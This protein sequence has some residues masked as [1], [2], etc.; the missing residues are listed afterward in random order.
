MVGCGNLL[1]GDDAAGPVLVRHAGRPGPARRACGWST[2]APPAWTSRSRCAACRGSS[3]WTRRGWAS[4]RAPSTGCP[5]PSSS[6]SPP[7]GEPAPFRWDQA[8][9]F[10]TWLLKDEYPEDITVWLVEGES[11][12][13]GA[14]LTPGCAGLCR[15]DRR[16]DR[17]RRDG[18]ESTVPRVSRSRHGSRRRSPASRRRWRPTCVVVEEHGRWIVYLDAVLASGAVRRKV[19][20]HHDERRAVH[21]ARIFERNVRRCITVPRARATPEPPPPRPTIDHRPSDDGPPA[22]A[23]GT[24]VSPRTSPRAPAARRPALARRHAPAARRSRRR[25]PPAL[26]CGTRRRRVARGPEFMRGCALDERHRA[27]G[28]RPRRRRPRH[29]LQPRRPRRRR[30]GVG[31]ARGGDHRRARARSSTR[32]GSASA[33]STTRPSADGTT[34][35]VAAVV[36]SARASA[37]IEQG[38]FG[39]AVDEL[40]AGAAAAAEAGSPLLAGSLRLTRAELLRERLDDPAAAA[41]EADLAR[42]AA[43]TDRATRTARRTAGDARAWPVR[44]LAGDRARRS[45]RGGGRPDRGRRRSSARTPT[46]RCSPPST[47]TSRSP[48]W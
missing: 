21:A 22:P 13:P 24:A 9:G 10:A 32:R 47:S 26:V 19:G 1:R 31:G 45:A 7:G 38:D 8:L 28:R 35:E 6:T 37:A 27:G 44:Q 14:P 11:F 42:A 41:R 48:T 12:E 40:G 16:R 3:S 39:G 30:R 23:R 2:A 17:G 20:E 18:M 4:S 25:L 29:P 43:A 15:A 34:G 46:P 33:C 36:R 5:A